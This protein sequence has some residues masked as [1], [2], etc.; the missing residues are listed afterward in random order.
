MVEIRIGRYIAENHAMA[1]IRIAGIVGLRVH[2]CTREQTKMS[3]A[4]AE[5]VGRHHI[6][7]DHMPRGVRRLQRSRCGGDQVQHAPWAG[8]YGLPRAVLRRHDGG[9]AGT[10]LIGDGVTQALRVGQVAGEQTSQQQKTCTARIQPGAKA[11]SVRNGMHDGY[12]PMT[13]KSMSRPDAG[14]T[15][16]GKSGSNT[17]SGADRF[18]P[19]LA[20]SPL[21]AATYQSVGR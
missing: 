3:A 5:I 17:A 4:G 11:A 15:L 12:P 20:V 16:P 2:V 1:A 18:P 7:L 6:E 13:E 14:Q 10:G 19:W 9:P 21:P 8:R